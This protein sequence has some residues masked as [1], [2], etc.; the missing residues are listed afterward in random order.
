MTRAF[1]TAEGGRI[2]RARPIHF[3][4]NGRGFTGFEGDTLASALLANGVRLVARSFKYHRPRG[5]LTA[6]SEEP[7]ALVRVGGAGRAL[8]NTRATQIELY[9][10]L[11]AESQNCWPA[12]ELDWGAAADAFARLL[13][14]G[15]YYKTFK[16]PK[17]WWLRYEHYIRRAAGMGR[18]PAAPDRDL[19]DKRHAHCDVLIV[20]GGPAGLSA[21]LAAGQTGARVILADE[22]S[23]LGGSLLAE[24]ARLGESTAPEWAEDAV[25]ELRAMPEVRLLPRATVFG[26]YDHNG[27]AIVERVADHVSQPPPHAPRQRLWTVRAKQVVLA[28]GAHERP[29]VFAGNDRPGILLAGAARTYLNRYGVH[30]GRRVLIFTN[31][32]SAYLYALDVAASGGDVAAVVDLRAEPSQHPA[33][34]RMEELRIDVLRG[35]AV[36]ATRG[37]LRLKSASV[38]PLDA[39]GTAV[40]GEARRIYCDAI[41]MSGGWSPAIHLFSQSKG[42]IDYDSEIAAFVPGRAAQATRSAG[43]CA[44][45]FDLSRCFLDGYD[46]GKAAAADCGFTAEE[47]TRPLPPAKETKPGPIRIVNPVPSTRPVGQGQKHFVDFQNDVTAADIALAAREGYGAVEHAKRYTTAGMGTDQGKTSNLN[48]LGL[49]AAQLGSEIPAVGTTT[50]RPPYTP[51][52]FGALAGRDIGELYLPLRRTPMQSWHERAGAAFEDVGRWRRPFYYPRPGET[53]REAV[54]REVLAVRNAVGVLDASTLGKIDIKGPDAAVLL[55]RVYTNDWARL[56]VGRCRYGVM[57]REDGMVLDDGV[58][59]RLGEEHFLMHTTSGNAERVAAWLEEWLQTEWPS[60]RA[61][62]TAV[63]EQFATVAVAGPFARRLL[64]PLCEGIDFAPAAFPHMAVREGRAAGAPARVFRVSYTGELS[65]EV[66]VPAR[67]GMALWQALLTAGEAY[68]V[69]P[70]GTEAMHVLRAEKGYIMVGQETDGTVTPLDLGLERAISTRKDFLG[71]RSL[72]RADMVAPDR[73][74]LIGLLTESPGE[75]LPDG[76]QIVADFLP[77]RPMEALGHVTS[78]YFSPTLGRSIALAL[79]QGGRRRIGNRLTVP[80]GGLRAAHAVVVEPVFYDPEG[81]RL[82]G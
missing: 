62:C 39:A 58:T 50:F 34:W 15:F 25:A 43:A 48:A 81:T 21:A 59:A 74:Q 82:H 40:T 72:S 17:R 8:P 32:D 42:T 38:M 79:L 61:R 70:F 80:L 69:T 49:L 36:V 63:T 33:A 13:P 7:N 75:V 46:A 68:G 2:D 6:G 28:T 65:Y 12:V 60:L 19:Y 56:A 29:L 11:A 4:F 73:K 52:T 53:V 37:H 54:A 77:N 57:C 20:G 3:T 22:Q 51:V 24:T 71:K 14:A 64:A 10:G 47:E 67:Y 23:E 76:A 44:G 78:S 18:V 41:A 45:S 5:I 9:E 66:N 55:D 16:R 1:R 27:L 26:Y 31:N 35:H 30:A